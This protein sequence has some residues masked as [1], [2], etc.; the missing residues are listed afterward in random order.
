MSVRRVIF[1]NVGGDILQ[2][3][4]FQMN[5]RG[6]SACCDA[7]SQYDRMRSATGPRGVPGLLVVKRLIMPGFIVSDFNDQRDKALT[8]L[9]TWVAAGKIKI[10]EDVVSGLENAPAALVGLLARENRGKRMAK[11]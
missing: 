7:I 6:R 5:L 11:V 9:Q 3:C 4:L 10:A 1:D 8:D 2:A